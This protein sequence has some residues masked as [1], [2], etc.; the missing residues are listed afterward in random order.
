ME[1]Q[2]RESLSSLG[3]QEMEW[4]WHLEEWEL[5]WC[6]VAAPKS[7]TEGHGPTEKLLFL[8]K[9]LGT[10][11]L[12][13]TARS[14]PVWCLKFACVTNNSRVSLV[15]EQHPKTGEALFLGG[16]GR[17]ACGPV[18]CVGRIGP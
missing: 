2:V 12:H 10:D 4:G 6:S 14:T 15:L 9:S 13:S 1:A 17:L 5:F 11:Y 7:N 18:D 8:R 16:L 3:Q